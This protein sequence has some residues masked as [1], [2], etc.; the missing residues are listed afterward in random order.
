MLNS[1]LKRKFLK[2][3]YSQNSPDPQDNVCRKIPYIGKTSTV[4]GRK[5]KKH[6]ICAVFSNKNN[7]KSLLV[8][9]KI[10]KQ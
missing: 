1:K 2:L 10:L 9:N 5:L 8:N 3:I 6:N 4:I 7:L